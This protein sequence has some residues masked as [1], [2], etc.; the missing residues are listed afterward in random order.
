MAPPPR[1]A[2]RP[3]RPFRRSEDDRVLGGVCGGL[4]RRLGIPARPL[5]VVAVL[6]VLAAG[7]G[8][9]L[10]TVLWLAIP[11]KGEERSIAARI[12]ADR[13]E[14][15]IVLSVST[16]V[17]ALL[18]ALEAIGLPNMGTIAWPLGICAVGVL[19]VWRGASPDERERLEEFVSSAAPSGLGT[20]RGWRSIAVRAA[21]GIAMVLIGIV[22]LSKVGDH[23]DP[24]RSA[25]VGAFL[26]SVGFFVIFAPW[27]LH[28]LRALTTERRE[29]VRA[30]ERAN[31]AAHVHDSVLQT[32]SLIQRSA[33]DPNEVVRLARLQERELRYWLFNPAS[34][35]QR[36]G[37][38]SSVAEACADLERD[39]EDDYGVGVELVVVGDC[40]LDERVSALLA[41]GREAS[42]NSAKWS[43]ASSISVYAEVEAAC[44][45]M[46]VRDVGAGFD[47]RAV[48]AD[49]H[50]ISGSIVE[51]MQRAGGQAVVRSAPGTG[52]EVELTVP[53]ER[54]TP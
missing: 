21:V 41:A 14:L 7:L 24:G 28:T 34:F 49:R 25:L 5:R 3:E 23:Q 45:T 27:W 8:L 53:R 6:L 44:V 12:G 40:P 17:L 1:R 29:R 2:T 11:R 16:V 51:R 31:L 4:A 30:E 38:P 50:G 10:Y 18:V 19:A 47:T 35:G 36:H 32:L 48:P 20:N 33:R 37:Q 39:V 26:L 43:G 15:Q 42:V 46:F 52:T 9:V 22:Q 13:R 54:P